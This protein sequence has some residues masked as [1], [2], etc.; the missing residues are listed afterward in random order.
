MGLGDFLSHLGE[1]VVHG[2][3]AGASAVESGL[4]A[5]IHYT[6]GLEAATRGM[7]W[8]YDNGVSQ[9]ITTAALMSSQYGDFSQMPDLL[10]GANWAKTWHA[11]N[12]V[13]P[14][15]AL[16]VMLSDSSNQAGRDVVNSP[17]RYYTPPTSDLPPGFDQLPD[18]QKQQILKDA[19]MPAVGNQ[20]VENMRN[21]SKLFKYGTGIADL[22]LSWTLDPTIVAGKVIGEARRARVVM[23]R[24]EVGWTKQDIDTIMSKSVVNKT[25]DYLLANRENPQ[26]LNNLPM[27]K[28]SGLGLRLG[29]TAAL[30]RTRDEVADFVRVG[31]G[32][33][34]AIESLEMKNTL[35]A[36]RLEQD[37]ARLSRLSL[38]RGQYASNPN[39]SAII[40]KHMDR[41]DAQINA[42]TVLT[43]RYTEVL[44][45]KELLD[46][47]HLSRWGFARA[48]E[49]TAA[50]NAYQT[51]TARIARADQSG[52]K[53]T[54][55]LGNSRSKSVDRYRSIT[56]TTPI[57]S[58][59]AM[60]AG[61]GLFGGRIGFAERMAGTPVEL[62][63]TKSMIHGVGDFFST[64]I[65]LV[66]S[67]KEAH[68]NGYARV[69]GFDVDSMNELRGQ[70]SRIPGLSDETRSTI[71]NDYLKTTSDG[72]RLAHL[73][74]IGALGAA[75]VAEK[76]GLEAEAGL[77]IYQEHLKRQFK[78]LGDQ[79]R[80]SV[81]PASMPVDIGNGVL[82]RVKVDEFLNDNGK[83][84][85]HPNT[86]SKLANGHVFQDLD[87][88]DKVLARHGSAL[89]AIRESR[90]GN[91]DWLYD[92]ADYT[93]SLFKLSTLLRLGYIPR[94]AGDDLAGQQARLGA[95]SMMLRAGWGV[96]N[97]ATNVARRGGQ[98]W[99]DAQKASHQAGLKYAED[100]LSLLKPQIAPLRKS[101]ADM[102]KQYNKAADASERRYQSALLRQANLSPRARPT[103][104]VKRQAEIDLHENQAMVSRKLASTLP[105]RD[106]L[107]LRD[108]EA[109]QAHLESYRD[110]AQKKIAE[111]EEPRQ[112]VFQ[113]SEP[114]DLPGGVKGPAALVGSHNAD[115]AMQLISPDEQLGQLF[116]R[117]K[118]LIHGNLL[119][120]F[121]HGGVAV[122]ASQNEPLHA[123]SW[124]HAINAQLA[125]DGL[126]RQAIAGA[127]IP[128]MTH[129]L[130]RTAEGR[131]YW[132]ELGLKMTTREDIAQRAM[133][134]V[135]HYLPL[136][137]IRAKALEPAGVSEEWL[138][139]AV[140]QPLREDVHTGQVAGAQKEYYRAM[141]RLSQAWFNFAATLPAKRLSRHP[142]FNQL[143]TG[144]MKILAKQRMAQGAYDTT[145]AGV[146]DMARAAR[147]LARKDMQKLVFD[148]A[149]RSDAAMALRFISPFMAPTAEAFQRW[150]RIIAEKPQIVGYANDFFNVPIALGAEQDA[151]GNTVA[152]GGVVTTIGPDGKAVTKVVPKGDRY[153]VARMP[154]SLAHSP[155]G[156]ALG[157]EPAS[158]QMRLSQNS[159]DIVTQGDPWFHPGVGPVVQIPVNELVKDKPSEAEV[160]RKLGILPFGPQ[161]GG[162]G[163]FIGRAAGFIEPATLKNFLTG[164]DTSDER[165]QQVKL[166][167]MQ[168]AAYEHEN[169]GKP[170][171]SA[172]QIADQTRNFWFFSAGAAF[173]QPVSTS[174]RDQY[175]FFRDQY[176]NL[177]RKNP[178][179]ADQEYLARYGESHFVFA[180]S[181]THNLSGIPATKAAHALTTQYASLLAEHPELGALIVGPEGNGPFSPEVYAYQLNHP[182]VPGGAEMERTKMSATDA[183]Q[184]NQRRLGW[185]KF[186]AFMNGLTHQL[187]SRGL[188]TFDDSGA[189]DLKA[190]KKGFISMFSSPTLPDG[191]TKN[192]FYNE[193]WSKDY[194][195][196]D[197]LKY[198]RLIPALQAVADSPLAQRKNRSDLRMLQQYLV[199]RK[200]VTKELAARKAGGGAGTLSANANA[201]LRSQWVRFV[202]GLMEA[203]VNF[204]DLYNRHLNRDLGVDAESEGVQ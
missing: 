164:L 86:V 162:S 185:A 54:G 142:L 124:A 52:D 174:R 146:E 85:I 166:Q 77:D 113:G 132:R 62:G 98:G 28:Y 79:S 25:I 80:F 201:D 82:A 139:E 130:K 84:V 42:D 45:S 168:R 106:R 127:S 126:A 153:I 76:H 44:K 188:K 121:D 145:V 107:K 178:L 14:G 203:D 72:E 105:A 120:S 48:E 129:W 116:A 122:S 93:T 189:E 160:A 140:P 71:I 173:T 170:M 2:V 190:Q 32:D 23:R 91:A 156:L 194:T 47:L 36:S 40:D 154:M 172:Q 182:L 176:N 29:P 30:L 200:V 133:S 181:Q 22:G 8:A 90:F 157:V 43:T 165:Y 195:S 59:D 60:P 149:H 95:A 147:S 58:R 141:D 3:E 21:E 169:F 100:E 74:N 68:P 20:Y 183:M 180:Q 167:I 81:A 111:L 109:R 196:L 155:V 87:E 49:K 110:L 11:A 119:R 177:R 134:D 135:N 39:L 202:S 10:K 15:Q 114:I 19:G 33:V 66:R 69:D 65:T 117:N 89:S 191:V 26:L 5:V 103:T 96:K 199:V 159:I 35:A 46:E 163:G 186:G 7:Q 73:R 97:L 118:Q 63:Y 198:D 34:D 175:Q 99:L 92:A 51:R 50:Q 41:L 67:L 187:V 192:P 64:P 128:E 101:V 204:G 31:M 17:L 123:Q 171:P 184:E 1:D 108:L 18:D 143:Y 179:T 13:S 4:G 9:P 161:G 104:I 152:R 131:A 78:A 38:S 75:K 6:P 197:P 94:V 115:Y 144:H 70:V 193:Q 158:G 37:T 150:G 136:P 61:K 55:L 125:Q 53:T 12:H 57:I 148:I 27:A 138:K 56:P 137:E 16:G 88:M 112:K 83:L 151:D 24:P 102:G